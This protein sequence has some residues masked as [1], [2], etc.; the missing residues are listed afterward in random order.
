MAWYVARVQGRDQW[1]N[2]T[3]ASTFIAISAPF[4][5]FGLNQLLP[6]RTA[7][8]PEQAGRVL[9]AGLILGGIVSV[10]VTV[11]LLL[12]SGLLDYEDHVRSL[13]MYGLVLTLVPFTEFT[14]C[15]AVVSGLERVDW[16]A[17][18]R[19]PL[20]VLRVSFSIGLLAL[21]FHI[22]VIFIG[23]SISY[24]VA[25]G[26]YLYLL[27]TRSRDIRLGV[28]NQLLAA[29][30]VEALPFVAFLAVGEAFKQ[31]GRVVLSTAWS[32]EALGV[33]AVGT[34]FIQMLYLVAPAIMTAIFPQ[35]VRTQEASEKKFVRVVNKL[36]KILLVAIFPL[37]LTVIGWSN[38]VIRLVYGVDYLD[39][40]PV[41]QI[42]AWGLVP[43]FAARL[44]YRVILASHYERVS[45]RISF[46]NSALN[47]LLSLWLVPRYGLIGASI[48]SAL[49]ELVGFS[50]NLLFVSR[51]VVCVDLF[52]A[53]VKPTACMLLSYGVFRV[54]LNWY[55]HRIGA[56]VAALGFFGAVV[57][58]SGTLS[59]KEFFS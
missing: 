17:L 56:W 23:L 12:V 19:L 46:I 10:C 40:I 30:F 38:L 51:K 54:L 37:A 57:W 24:L 29:V 27:L 22:R 9:S 16:I 39:A 5:F 41:M 1:G 15:E 48:V 58:V 44:L 50:Q 47:I 28:D 6:R 31:L 34:A 36:L 21:G 25:S 8:E 2:Y 11:I 7:Q 26:L 52:R 32:P 20:T 18:I 45:I 42:A 13:I 3:T 43:S 14:L 59:F 53:L 4:A 49:I 33:Y 55:G 35:L